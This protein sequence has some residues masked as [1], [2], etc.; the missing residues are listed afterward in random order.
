MKRISMVMLGMLGVLALGCAGR[1]RLEGGE[2]SKQTLRSMPGWYRKPPKGDQSWMFAPATATSRELQVALDRAQSD[3]RLGLATQLEAK[4]SALS[5]RFVEET[6]LARDAELLSE[7]EQTYKS[8]VSQVLIGSRAREQQFETENGVY[9]AWVLMELPVGEANKRL[10]EQ[11]RAQEQLYTR[12]RATEAYKELNK[13]VEK[14]E[15]SKAK[16]AP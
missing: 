5:R 6:G 4:Y 11:I 12:L 1:T 9:R 16:R 14:L 2:A 7:Y 13:E 8:V 15:A 3:G 10:L